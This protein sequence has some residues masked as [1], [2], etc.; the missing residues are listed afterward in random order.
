MFWGGW[1]GLVCFQLNSKQV[2]LLVLST[3]VQW[4]PGGLR[5]VCLCRHSVGL[6]LLLLLPCC[7]VWEHC[8]KCL[9]HLPAGR[10]VLFSACRFGLI[11][12]A[13]GAEERLLWEGSGGC[14][15]VSLGG[16]EVLHTG[17]FAPL[18]LVDITLPPK[19]LLTCIIPKPCWWQSL[20]SRQQFP[21]SWEASNAWCSTAPLNSSGAALGPWCCSLSYCNRCNSLI[22]SLICALI[23]N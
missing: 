19:T 16:A 2:V 10:V 12:W 21:L 18:C 11:Q 22:T 23:L 13:S 3:L 17:I 14:P 7:P 1:G 4:H 15:A 20:T 6:S 5:A 8:L 9:W